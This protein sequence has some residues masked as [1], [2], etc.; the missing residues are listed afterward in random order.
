MMFRICRPLLLVA[1][2]GAAAFAHAF[3]VKDLEKMVAELDSHIARNPAYEYPIKCTI[4]VDEEV[5]AGATVEFYDDE[6]KKPRALM[7]VNTGLIKHFKESYKLIRAVVAHELGHLSKGHPTAGRFKPGDLSNLH[8]RQR[9][10]E[11]DVVGASALVACGYPKQ[12][13]IDVLLEL[14]KLNEGAPLMSVVGA[15]HPTGAQ[16]AAEIADDPNVFRALA[17]FQIGL[18]FAENRKYGPAMAAFDRAVAKEPKL[19][20]A[21]TNAAQAAL[22]RYYENLP[23]NVRSLWFRPDFGPML[24]P[25]VAG[26]PAPVITDLDRQ[27]YQAAMTRINVA[28]QKDPNSVKAKE[29]LG[30][31]LVLDPDAGASN[32]KQGIDTLTAVAKVVANPDDQLRLANNLALGQQ[33]SGNLNAAVNTLLAAQAKTDIFNPTLGENLGA[34]GAPNVTGDMASLTA[35]VLQTWLENVPPANT[36]YAKV[37]A[38]YEEICR[39]NNYAVKKLETFPIY[40]CSVTGVIVKG[41]EISIFEPVKVAV[42]SFGRAD[43][44][45]KFSED[46]ADMLEYRWDNV[47]LNLLG[48]DDGVIRVTCYEPG[49]MMVIK[50]RDPSVE[51]EYRVTVGM[52]KADLAK[53]LN[54]DKG[55]TK[56]FVRCGELEDWLYF[57]SLMM[58]VCL[59]DDVVTG[60]TVSPYDWKKLKN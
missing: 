47:Q 19:V 20:E 37:K 60:I 27:M 54:V 50:P 10:H 26:R 36:N 30:L 6:T 8:T 15:D 9:E 24:A 59:K 52:T 40:L 53:I 33:R 23:T 21:Y 7:I 12:D 58:G 4:E 25:P 55:V 18:A 38:S 56:P 17:E 46:Y 11:A 3:D 41:K 16:R 13:M 57:P 49:A 43:R 44:A 32:L 22:V 48:D 1:I 51:G 29:L 28:I 35:A 14:D 5:N 45:W 31:A 2:A 39:K 34:M 42:D